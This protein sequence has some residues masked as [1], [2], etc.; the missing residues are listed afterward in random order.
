MAVVPNFQY[1][2]PII[3]GLYI[4]FLGLF[5]LHFGHDDIRRR[6]SKASKSFEYFWDIWKSSQ[7]KLP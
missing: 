6:L 3:W 1:L 4:Y 5:M 2:A 7:S